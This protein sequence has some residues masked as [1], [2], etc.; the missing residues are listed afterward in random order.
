MVTL[1]TPARS[2]KTAR[3]ARP[4]HVARHDFETALGRLP[5]MSRFTTKRSLG[6]RLTQPLARL[7]KTQRTIVLSVAAGTAFIA[8]DALIA[9][10]VIGRMRRQKARQESQA[11]T[12]AR[13]AAEASDEIVIE[14]VVEELARPAVSR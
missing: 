7:S 3:R 13:R 12:E 1:R 10:I 9:G 6:R 14:T 8:V 2:H 5:V 11:E 4:I